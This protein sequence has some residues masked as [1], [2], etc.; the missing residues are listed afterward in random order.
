[1]ALERALEYI[2]AQPGV[3]KATGREIVQHYLGTSF[4]KSV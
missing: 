1:V 2:C 4:A 3:W